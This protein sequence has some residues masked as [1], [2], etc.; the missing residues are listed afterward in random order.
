MKNRL[1]LLL[2]VL[3]FIPSLACYTVVPQSIQGSGNL[4]TQSFD[5]SSFDRVRLDGSGD[6]VAG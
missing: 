2:L 5:V 6:V 1:P 4:E 3:F